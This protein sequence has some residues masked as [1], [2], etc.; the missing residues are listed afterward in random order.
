MTWWELFFVN[1][2]YT[3]L[4]LAYKKEREYIW[5]K[6]QHI[7]L[8]VTKLFLLS[9]L[10]GHLAS[11]LSVLRAQHPTVKKEGKVLHVSFLEHKC[12][13]DVFLPYNR[14]DQQVRKYALKKGEK[15]TR[16]FTLPKGVTYLCSAQDFGC[17]EIIPM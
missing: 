10:A 7:C 5:G 13:Y 11:V 6:L 1:L 12:R 15:I 4:L 9:S 8:E 16:E 17:D 2:F 3:L 14:R